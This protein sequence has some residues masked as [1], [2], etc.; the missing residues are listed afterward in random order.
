MTPFRL[1]AASFIIWFAGA[2]AVSAQTIIIDGTG[3]ASAPADIARISL[4]VTQEGD[5]PEEAFSG[6][7]R[8]MNSVFQALDSEGIDPLDRQT[9]NINMSPRY[10]NNSLSENR[11]H[12]YVANTSVE[13]TVRDVAALGQILTAIVAA[14][15]TDIQGLSYDITD[16]T[17]LLE[18]ARRDA[19]SDAMSAAAVLADAAGATLGALKSIEDVNPAS[20]PAPGFAR[21]ESM[22]LD[23]LPTAGGSISITHQIR[24]TFNLED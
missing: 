8:D 20:G 16:K 12:G 15:A 9:G 11:T 24:M 4:G 21:M 23:D 10:D 3:E 6:L 5:T 2:V 7:R 14:D 22:A 18:M 17:A 19:V 13:I 1:L